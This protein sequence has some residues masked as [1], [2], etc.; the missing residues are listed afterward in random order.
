MSDDPYTV[1]VTRRGGGVLQPVPD[2]IRPRGYVCTVCGT[3][4]EWG[5]TWSWFGSYKDAE[6]A[7]GRLPV[8]CADPCR[9]QWAQD[10]A[11][12]V[13]QAGAKAPPRGRRKR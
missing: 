3:A 12:Y 1:T 10:N 6:R 13:D 8:F 2:D 9:D 4:G 11:R 5:P 7:P